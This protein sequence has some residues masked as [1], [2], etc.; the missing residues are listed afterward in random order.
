MFLVTLE[1]F[2]DI[3][4]PASM[5]QHPSRFDEAEQA[6]V[7]EYDTGD[8]T[9]HDLFMDPGEKI[10]FKVVA[11][12]FSE[13]SPQAPQESTNQETPPALVAYS[14]TVDIHVLDD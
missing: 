1:F 5:L 14:I 12:N 13:V 10:R 7:W 6:W 11:E 2:E 8:G 9:K 3:L 4:I